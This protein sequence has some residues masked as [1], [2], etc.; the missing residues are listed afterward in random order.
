MGFCPFMWKSGIQII[1]GAGIPHVHKM[2]F[3]EVKDER[4]CRKIY[5]ILLLSNLTILAW[6]T[7]FN[8]PRIPCIAGLR[9]LTPIIQTWQPRIDLRS[10]NV[11][12][13]VYKVAM[14]QIFSEY[15]SV[16]YQFSFPPTALHSFI[17][18]SFILYSFNIEIVVKKPPEEYHA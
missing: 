17:I 15:F 11:K 4:T 13:V 8:T 6:E 9:H 2:Y 10:S 5:W 1:M 12:N 7:K 14:G 16:P 3:S 18:L